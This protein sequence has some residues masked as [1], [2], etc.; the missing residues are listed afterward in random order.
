[1]MQTMTNPKQTGSYYTPS[2]LSD[3]LTN[4]LFENYYLQEETISILEPCCGDGRFLRSLFNLRNLKNYSE[5]RIEIVDINAVELEKALNIC[6]THQDSHVTVFSSNADYLK[7]HS[8]DQKK[9]SLIIGNPPYIKKSLL[10]ESQIELCKNVYHKAGVHFSSIKNIWPA[11]LI[12]SV[13]NLD[14]NGILC[15]ILPAEILQVKYSERIR[16]Y[17]LSAFERIEI[18]AFNELIF[19]KTLQDVIVLIG[20]KKVS[21]KQKQGVSFYQVETLND[22]KEL[23][24][25]EKNNNVHRKSL[26]K[27]TNYILLPDELEFIDKLKQVLK[28]V[29]HYCEKA[30]AGIVT[31]ANQYFVVNDEIVKRYRLRRLCKPLISKGSLIQ[32]K[33]K[34]TRQDVSSLQQS[35]IP[36]NFIHFGDKRRAEFGKY[37][38][39]YIQAGEEQHLHERYKCRLRKN[40]Y[41]VPSVWVS[42]GMF[43]KRCHLHPK[44]LI[45]D[46]EVY[47]S[48]S[49][50]RVNMKH[51]FAMADLVFSF[52]NTLTF[53]LAELEGR[54]YGGGVLELTPNEFKNLA[55]PYYG[56][57][58]ENQLNHLELM[59]RSKTDIENILNYTDN[60]VLKSVLKLGK[61][62]IKKLGLIY[63]KL[64]E[65]R[66]KRKTADEK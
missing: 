29:R 22:L 9:Y 52:Y 59:F 30:E 24:F 27:W 1:M 11:F 56:N 7:F 57:V 28:P 21:K 60:I 45:N 37:A 25:T 10:T 16:K 15:L 19:K 6:N 44:L 12:N 4:H 51:E 35:G 65:R 2:I 32:N 62:E 53:I 66:L 47:V 61:A 3:F 48:D 14:N 54:Y 41:H 8:A 36:V 26:E 50:Y 38:Q 58:S 39:K 34:I 18:F 40:W 5:V 49:F 46:A 63:G 33:I 55:V 20:I 43:V 31:G 42:E 64:V 23:K 13:M 17:L